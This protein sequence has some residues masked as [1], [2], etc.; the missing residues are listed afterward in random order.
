MFT[1]FITL[2]NAN[3]YPENGSWDD[4]CIIIYKTTQFTTFQKNLFSWYHSL[5]CTAVWCVYWLQ[6]LPNHNKMSEETMWG[7]WVE[8]EAQSPPSHTLSGSTVALHS[9]LQRNLKLN[10]WT[11]VPK[12]T[13]KDRETKYTIISDVISSPFDRIYNLL[14]FLCL[15][16]GRHQWYIQA[17]KILE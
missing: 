8:K 3:E 16:T 4:H 11:L 9:M 7:L 17:F 1:F 5:Q 14:K 2:G 6:N 15:W 10:I 13:L 12:L